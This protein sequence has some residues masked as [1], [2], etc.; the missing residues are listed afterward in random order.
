MTI[1]EL[2]SATAI[3]LMTDHGFTLNEA[4]ET[5]DGSVKDNEEIWNENAS[6]EDLAE[7]LAS[8]DDL[9]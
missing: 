8:E 3:A 6:P 4:E 5:V 1:E 2:K 9:M 7:F